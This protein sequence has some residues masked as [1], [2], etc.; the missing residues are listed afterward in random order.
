[1][2]KAHR[3]YLLPGLVGVLA[4]IGSLN[5]AEAQWSGNKINCSPNTGGTVVVDNVT[6]GTGSSSLTNFSVNVGCRSWHVSDPA[7]N[8]TSGG[9]CIGIPPVGAETVDKRRAYLNGN[10]GGP[11]IEFQFVY[12]GGGAP[13]IGAGDG[14]GGW[15]AVNY[16]TSS[17]STTQP[18]TVGVGYNLGTNNEILSVRVLPGQSSSSLVAGVYT[19]EPHMMKLWSG[20]SDTNDWGYVQDNRNWENC[21]ST[22]PTNAPKFFGP[23]T[24]EIHVVPS[25]TVTTA[26]N[27]DFGDV[28]STSV[29]SGNIPMQTGKITVDCTT[30]D[31]YAIKMDGGQSGDYQNRVMRLGG[32]GGG[33]SAPTIR[34][35]LYHP[36]GATSVWGDTD[37]TKHV[38]NPGFMGAKTF[39]VN[40]IIPPQSAPASGYFPSDVY[41]DVVKVILEVYP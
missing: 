21:Q 3:R 25:C 6:P 8:L 27:V 37:A 31:A 39:D 22:F 10:V 30:A 18:P 28:L 38:E 19:S 23:V 29:V 40:A 1:M 7:N 34:Y 41:S 16:G 33:G 9:Y 13:Y 35:Q 24:V 12:Q 26:Q 2:K 36:P 14:S 32:P 11:F 17:G 4:F 15:G 5:V 20:T